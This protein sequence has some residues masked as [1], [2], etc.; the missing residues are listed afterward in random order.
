M[1]VNREH[2]RL[3][4]ENFPSWLCPTCPSGA[5]SIDKNTFKITETGPS[6]EAHQLDGWEP[7]WI[8]SRFTGM[9]ICQN[10]SCGEVV[11]ICGDVKHVEDH[12]W[13]RQELNWAKVFRPKSLW[14]AP[15]IFPF[16]DKCPDTV[17]EE[18]KRAFS[19]FWLDKESCANRLRTAV[20]ALLNDRRVARTTKSRKSGKRVPLTLHGRIEKFKESEPE[21]AEYLLAIKW[22]GNVGSH[23][24]SA[25]LD[26]ED[27]LGA[28]EMFEHVVERIYVKRERQLN[29]LAKR[30]I[31][32]K[33]KPAQVSN[34][35]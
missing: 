16:Y 29:K 26:A 17:I 23:S 21:S 11:V 3:Q 30:M 8:T 14:P 1:P 9:L 2:W 35:R 22:L 15:P 13:E 27:L 20:E 6:R 5:L 28:F 31:S 32:R 34:R 18:L 10:S 12:D 24:G 4:F 33:G 7:G 19:L 25:D